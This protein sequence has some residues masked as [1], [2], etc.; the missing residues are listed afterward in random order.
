MDTFDRLF[1]GFA[2]FLQVVLIIHFAIRKQRFDLT[3][4]FGWIVYALS[5]L[6]L[7]LSVILLLNGKS[8]DLWLAG[9]LYLVWSIYGYFVEYVK[10]INWR[11]PFLKSIGIPYV[12]LYLITIMFYWWPLANIYKPLWYVYALFF[13]ATTA[14][15]VTSHKPAAEP[16]P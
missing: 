2:F 16:N 3:K 13:I 9:F 14:L 7:T 1:I 6:A 5:I 10:K 15:N 8:W 11:T 12:F 4:R